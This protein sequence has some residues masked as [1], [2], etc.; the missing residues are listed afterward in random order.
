M[1]FKKILVPIDTGYLNEALLGTAISAAQRFQAHIEALYVPAGRRDD[2]LNY[3]TVGLSDS[4]KKTVME[5]AARGTSEQA[6]ALRQA[7]EKVCREHKVALAD[8]PPASAKATAAWHEE[9]G[10]G[11]D[12]LVRRGRLSDLIFVAR[13]GDSTAA[14]ETFETALLETGQPV[15]VVPPTPQQCIATRITIGWNASAEAARAIAEALPCLLSADAVTVLASQKR[16]AS[17][18][19]LVDYLGWH[20]IKPAVRIFEAGSRAVG[21]TLLAES[22]ELGA[23]LLVIGGYTHTRARQ[24]LFGGVTRH[25]FEAAD[26][27]VM[28]AH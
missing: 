2:I 12:V 13:P 8:K 20:G 1:G 22:H 9:T 21:E 26:I 7:F 10:Y 28:M 5:A 11:A 19:E 17:A 14:A 27:P 25:I 23:D 4:L 15:V 18:Q 3:G 6:S 24:L 16:A